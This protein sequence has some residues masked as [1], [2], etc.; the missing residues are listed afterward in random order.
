[1]IRPL[2]E[3]QDRLPWDTALMRIALDARTIYSPRRRGT[4]KNLLDLYRSLSA[5]RSD[6]NVTAYH[7]GEDHTL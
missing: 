7:R 4:G 6:W 3:P 5:L 1:M 2:A